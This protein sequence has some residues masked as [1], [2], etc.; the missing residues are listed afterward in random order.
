MERHVSHR[1]RRQPRLPAIRAS[2]HNFSHPA[3]RQVAD[4]PSS[5]AVAPEHSEHG[6]RLTTPAPSPELGSRDRHRETVAPSCA[7]RST[8][9]TS[10][11]AGA[12]VPGCE[13]A[14]RASPVMTRCH[15]ASS[16]LDQDCQETASG[17][18]RH[19]TR[20]LP[21]PRC[22]EIRK[23]PAPA[24]PDLASFVVPFR[25]RHRSRAR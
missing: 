12:Q 20:A 7:L 9:V 15:D 5:A 11:K 8:T 2:F 10:S 18:N 4:G 24:G 13:E 22:R 14:N 3:D 1:F 23:A 16:G 19:S 17:L 21:E 6:V 25:P